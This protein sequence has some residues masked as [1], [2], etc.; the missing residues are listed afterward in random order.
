MYKLKQF[1]ED[2]IVKEL[3]DL[4]LNLQGKYAYFKLVKK[5]F[6]TLKAIEILQN[7]WHVNKIGFAGLKDKVAVTE[8]F[9][10][11]LG[12][13]ENNIT[14]V[15]E[16]EDS[17]IQTEFVG[18][19]KVPISLGDHKEN[20]FEITVR[21][22]KI[23]PKIK[24]EFINFFGEQ[25]FS[26]NNAEIG[27]LLIKRDFKSAVNLILENHPHYK[28]DLEPFIASNNFISALRKLPKKLLLLYLNSFQSKIWNDLTR[29]HAD[30]Y[31]SIPLI[32]FGISH[33]LLNSIPYKPKDFIFKEFPELSL[34]GSERQTVVIAEDLKISRLEDD[35]LNVGMKKLKLNFALPKGSYATE[36]IKQV[37]SPQ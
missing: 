3:M 29:K 18:R 21:S 16:R 17:F 32:G 35:D 24:P 15:F 25:R 6:S 2:F 13:S 8:Q 12:V 1:P 27:E 9:C 37:L 34:E 28:K 19:G 20:Y 5:N 10:S 4:N 31:E 33:E 36:F 7:K 23:L 14:W 30:R 22:I 11:V 26:K